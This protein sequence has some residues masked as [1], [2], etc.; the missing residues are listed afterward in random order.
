[1]TFPT[2]APLPF[3]MVIPSVPTSVR[4][5]SAE[6]RTFRLADPVNVPVNPVVN[7]FW[8]AILW[9]VVFISPG[10]VAE[11]LCKMSW[12]LKSCAPFAEGVPVSIV[13]IEVIAVSKAGPAINCQL[14]PLNSYK[15]PVS[16]ATPKEPVVAVAG[17]AARL[18]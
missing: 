8:P 18:V 17:N 14:T 11:A 7:V 13:P 6:V 4:F 5:P 3:P 2:V 15:S 1:M 12:L 16:A 10:R 9:V